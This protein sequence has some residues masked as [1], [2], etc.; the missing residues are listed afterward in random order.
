MKNLLTSTL[1]AWA[2]L[3]SPGC[4]IAQDLVMPAVPITVE[5][6]VRDPEGSPVEGATV[7]LTLPRYRLGDKNQEAEAKTSKEGV[8]LVSGIAQQDYMLSVEKAGYYWTQG[9]HRGINDEKSF[10]QYAVGVQKT[11]MVLRP[12]R[13]PIVGISK[14]V[15]RL[16]LPA[17][18]T[19]L[20]FDLEAGD[21]IAPYGKG[22]KSDFIFI[23]GGSFKTVNDYDQLLTLSFSN[24][25]DGIMPFRHP[26]HLGSALKWPYEAPLSG[27]ESQRIWRKTFDGKKRASNLDNSGE[28]NYLFRVR[29]ELDEKG[30]V[31]RAMY[32]VISNEVVI[33]G[34]NEIGRN[35]SFTYALNPDWTRNLEFDPAKTAS[36]PR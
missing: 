34:N 19:P 8:A 3:V 28:M 17:F 18:D 4:A 24:Q 10:E 32:G 5:A 29:T 1:G 26:K 11:E 33:G 12:I 36:S 13:N 9:P 15:D 16:K 31:R 22:K 30:N 23:V 20:G 7:H 6:S 14:T 25:G 21:W 2:L 35:V 27:Y